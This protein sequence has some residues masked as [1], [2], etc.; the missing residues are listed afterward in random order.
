M[1]LLPRYRVGAF[2]VLM[3]IASGSSAHAQIVQWTDVVHDLEAAKVPPLPPDALIGPF[4]LVI[5]LGP[6]LAGNQP[7]LDAFNRAA[8]QWADH[9]S[10]AITVTIDADMADLGSSSII[11]QASSVSLTAGHDYIRTKWVADADPDDGILAALPTLAQF[12]A[13]TPAGF[14]LDSSLTGNKSALKAIGGFGDLDATFGAT[15]ATITF[16]TQFSFDF[17]NSNGVTPGTVDFETVAAH[18]IGHALGFT[19]RVDEIDFRVNNGQTANLGPR[20]LDMFRF[21][22]GTAHDPVDAATFTTS[23]RALTPGGDPIT[24]FISSVGSEAVENR[25]STGFYTGDGRQASHWKDNGLTGLLIGIMDPTLASGVVVPLT[26][27][28]LRVID[29]VGYDISC[30]PPEPPTSASSDRDNFCADDPGTITLTATGGSGDTLRWFDDSCGGN[31]IGTGNPLVVPSPTATTTYYAR[32]ENT[33]G[34]STCASV[35]VTVVPPAEVTQWSSVRAHGSGFGD[36]AIELD[37]SASGAAVV[38]ETRDGGVQQIVVDFSS[39]VTVFYTPGQVVIAGG[40]SLA[41]TGEGLVNAGTRLEIDLNGGMDETCATIDIGASV[42]CLTGDTDCAVRILSGDVNGDGSTNNTDKS[43][44]ASL[45]GTLAGPDNIRFDSNLDGS[46][47]NT[48]KSLVAS[49]NGR[50]ASC[51]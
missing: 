49:R 40:G 45:N 13:I 25:M 26:S 11:G 23:A 36:L 4:T 14:G 21:E 44:V 34:E 37:A 19:S 32:W 8:Q 27:A 9:I 7:A 5:N 12:S 22:N 17:D 3:V 2:A 51:P 41:V 35:T 1:S 10:D 15:D 46:I 50:S 33:C 43:W 24:D 28:D 20:L 42:S 47:N 6:T 48:D 39:D 29:L 31:D 38:S 16:N 18:E 30:T